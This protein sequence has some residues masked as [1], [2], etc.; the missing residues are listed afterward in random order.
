[1]VWTYP[2]ENGITETV[3][4]F[5]VLVKSS[6]DMVRSNPIPMIRS[7]YSAHG[8]FGLWFG[9]EIGQLPLLVSVRG[10]NRPLHACHIGAPCL[11]RKRYRWQR[12]QFAWREEHDGLGTRDLVFWKRFVLVHPPGDGVCLNNEAV[13]GHARLLGRKQKARTRRLVDFGGTTTTFRL[14]RMKRSAACRL[15]TVDVYLEFNSG[16]A[17]VSADPTWSP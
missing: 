9:I 8:L 16:S 11:Q 2:E 5:T 14:R 6:L 7:L 1:L 15:F 13:G 4:S 3:K 12:S 10:L 17:L